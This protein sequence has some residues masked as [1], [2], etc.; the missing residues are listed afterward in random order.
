MNTAYG[1]RKT[2]PQQLVN[3]GKT[4]LSSATT[5]ISNN[6]YNGLSWCLLQL[7]AISQQRVYLGFRFFLG[8]VIRHSACLG[9]GKV[10]ERTVVIETIGDNGCPSLMAGIA[11]RRL[12]VSWGNNKLK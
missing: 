12:F 5:D 8:C 2:K 4:F 10:R 3:P 7:Q 1:L 9:I 11:S 6:V